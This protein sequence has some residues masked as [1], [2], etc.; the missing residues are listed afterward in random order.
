MADYVP[1][2][3]VEAVVYWTLPSPSIVFKWRQIA[4]DP[5]HFNAAQL[6]TIPKVITL[7]GCCVFTVPHLNKRS[8]EMS[9]S[10]SV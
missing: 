2:Q 1:D 8:S 5:A 3:L 6:K 7:V 10:D 9:W 4:S